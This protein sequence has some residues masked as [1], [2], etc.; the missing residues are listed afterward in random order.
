LGFW[1]REREDPWVPW[2]DRNGYG[3]FTK[4]FCDEVSA[5]LCEV[6]WLELCR[7]DDGAAS[8]KEEVLS[9]VFCERAMGVYATDRAHIGTS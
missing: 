2:E 8:R 4:T 9:V 3:F 7:G 6:F 5:S 1:G